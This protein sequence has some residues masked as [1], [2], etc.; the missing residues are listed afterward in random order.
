MSEK[1]LREGV[2]TPV[3]S[4]GINIS[5]KLDKKIS[6]DFDRT[7]GFSSDRNSVFV[8]RKSGK[9]VKEKKG[10]SGV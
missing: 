10:E 2:D 4:I 5:A 7:R 3:L 6:T 1:N 9:K 8:R